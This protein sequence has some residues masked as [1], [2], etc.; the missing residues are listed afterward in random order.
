MSGWNHL[1]SVRSGEGN[2]RSLVYPP[3][4]WLNRHGLCKI[5]PQEMLVLQTSMQLEMVVSSLELSLTLFNSCFVFRESSFGF[6]TNFG[7]D[8]QSSP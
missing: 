7:L 4:E 2:Y 6:I 3:P 1:P 8:F 5:G